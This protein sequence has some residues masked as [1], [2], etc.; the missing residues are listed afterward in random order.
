[1]MT[2]PPSMNGFLII[3]Y[4]SNWPDLRHSRSH[5]TVRAWI[6]VSI[7]PSDC[8]D[9]AVCSSIVIPSSLPP[10]VWFERS[11]Q[12]LMVC[13]RRRDSRPHFVVAAVI[14]RDEIAIK[15]RCVFGKLLV[16]LIKRWFYQTKETIKKKKKQERNRPEMF[17]IPPKLGSVLQSSARAGGGWGGLRR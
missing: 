16:H 5:V 7:P 17:I 4:D 2:L 3:G 10:P 9:S 1:M 13:Y 15:K 8:A 11:F 6:I 12:S 14:Y